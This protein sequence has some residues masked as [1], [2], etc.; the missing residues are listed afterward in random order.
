MLDKIIGD[1][2]KLRFVIEKE[3][4]AAKVLVPHS[5]YVSVFSPEGEIIKDCP[6]DIEGDIV[7]FEIAP[8]Y[9]SKTGDYKAYFDMM[10]GHLKKT[11][12]IEFRMMP[13]TNESLEPKPVEGE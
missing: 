1:T 7:S 2:V 4:D 12:E 10:V 8:E 5:V 11:H 9:T 6:G 3:G 13:R